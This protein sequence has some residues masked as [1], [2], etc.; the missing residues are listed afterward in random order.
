MKDMKSL[1]VDL[2]HNVPFEE[3]RFNRVEDEQVS[4]RCNFRKVC[5][6]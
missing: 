4:L 6:V 1:L 3:E 2:E 5:R